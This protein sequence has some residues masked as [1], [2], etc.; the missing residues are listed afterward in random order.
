MRGYLNANFAHAAGHRRT[1]D[2][3]LMLGEWPVLLKF[4]VKE[5]PEGGHLALQ[6][7]IDLEESQL[8]ERMNNRLRAGS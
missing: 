1:I 6:D 4:M 7:V 5:G 2:R 8:P 3:T